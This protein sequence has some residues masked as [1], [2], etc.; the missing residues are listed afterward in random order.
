MQKVEKKHH[1][2]KGGRGIWILLAAL[3]LCG[4]VVLAL[5][6]QRQ[7]EHVPEEAGHTP[8]TGSITARD[9]NELV[10]VTVQRRGE[11]PWTM[12]RAEDGTLRLEAENSPVDEQ[13]ANMLTDALANLTYEDVFTED[14]KE[15]A[16]HLE[17]FGLAEPTVRA[18]GI[19]Q[20][21]AQVTVYVGDSADPEENSAYYMT[22]EGDDRLFAVN[23]GTVQDLNVERSLMYP[24][25]QP[26]IHSALLDRITCYGAD[27]RITKE[28]KL[29]GKVSDQ[30]AA[31]NWIVSVPFVYPADWEIMKNIRES[32]AS[33]RM[34]IWT[35]TVTDET[36]Q[37]W[38]LDAPRGRVEFHL[39]AGSTGTVSDL[40]VYD[41]Q[42]WEERTVV[43]TLGSQKSS[44]LDYVRY[45]DEVF[46]VNH[47]FL[48]VF[49][50][51]DPLTTAARYPVQT[52]FNSLERL[53]VTREEG[54]AVYTMLRFDGDTQTR[55]SGVTYGNA[56]YEEAAASGDGNAS[57]ETGT[58]ET[59]TEDAVQS[60]QE[61]QNRC[62]KNGEE[63]SWSGFEAAYERLLTVT[64][65]GRLPEG[66]TPKAA[67]TT[68]TFHTVSG[69]VHTVELSD[70]D[71]FHDA[72]TMDGHTLFYLIKGG[73]TALP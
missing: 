53:T 5:T 38:G 70:F 46:T 20:D 57:S 41:V 48:S 29:N 65:S 69:G 64:V 37:T 31:E 10:S 50:D 67:H 30:D 4:S 27:G 16:D 43:L 44:T 63:I 22:V 9:P 35:G 56:A 73:M 32:A 18:T 42:D 66:Y 17:D 68:Y 19:F 39:A 2:R 12:L 49:T 47:F 61:T 15:Y 45:G 55:D 52:P 11:K 1:R 24:V 3:L 21:G 25:T 23:A 59:G 28:W 51:T 62:M 7:A 60:G 71:G 26:V 72:V 6:L 34:G 36:L 40:G 54:E 33:L 58:G 13:L 14:A 8:V